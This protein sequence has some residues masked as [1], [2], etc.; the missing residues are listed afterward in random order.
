MNNRGRW[1]DNLDTVNITGEWFRIRPDLNFDLTIRPITGHLGRSSICRLEWNLS[2]TIYLRC[3]VAI[4]EIVLF[5]VLI[6]LFAI[7]NVESHRKA[8][9]LFPSEI[10]RDVI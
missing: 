3:S 5:A 2:T 8:L 10:S 6:A 4:F 1:V 7:I 9:A